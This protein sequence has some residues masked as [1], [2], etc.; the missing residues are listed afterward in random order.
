MSDVAPLVRTVLTARVTPSARASRMGHGI[1]R[2]K[3]NA[4]DRG[5]TRVRVGAGAAYNGS[6]DP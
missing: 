6:R 2:A 1:S 4:V 5:T 3:G